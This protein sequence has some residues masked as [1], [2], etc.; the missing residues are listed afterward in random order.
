[1]PARYYLQALAEVP[2]RNIR[3]LGGKL[4]KQLREAGIKKMGEV[5]LL[6]VKDL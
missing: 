6:T 1:V 5:Q 2:I 3:M 4:G